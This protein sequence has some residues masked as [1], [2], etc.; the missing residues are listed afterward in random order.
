MKTWLSSDGWLTAWRQLTRTKRVIVVDSATGREHAC[1]VAVC[2][3]DVRLVDGAYHV[4]EIGEAPDGP[5]G[6]RA[7]TLGGL[8]L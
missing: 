1:Q 5:V 4:D 6:K 8:R 7:E 3:D 2:R